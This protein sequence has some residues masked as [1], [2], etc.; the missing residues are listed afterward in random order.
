MGLLACRPD[1]DQRPAVVGRVIA[2]PLHAVTLPQDTL[3]G[4][5]STSNSFVGYTNLVLL[6][7]LYG[8]S[9]INQVVE[10][11]CCQEIILAFGC[12]LLSLPYYLP[13]NQGF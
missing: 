12:R 11:S 1:I 10:E 2:V 8:K 13:C 3:T 6:A 5:H 9:Q 4:N 7:L